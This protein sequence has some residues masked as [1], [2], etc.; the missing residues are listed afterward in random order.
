MKPSREKAKG[1][2][3]LPRKLPG[4]QLDREVCSLTKGLLVFVIDLRAF[5]KRSVLI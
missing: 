4:S 5:V 2:N 1:V 3:V